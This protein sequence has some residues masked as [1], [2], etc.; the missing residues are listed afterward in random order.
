MPLPIHILTHAVHVVYIC[1][2]KH[3]WKSPPPPPPDTLQRA[4]NIENAPYILSIYILTIQCTQGT[5]LSLYI[6]MEVAHPHLPLRWFSIENWPL[7]GYFNISM[8]TM[9]IY[10]PQH[11]KVS[12][13]YTLFA[14]STCIVH[15]NTVRVDID[16]SV[17]QYGCGPVA[18]GIEVL[19]WI[20]PL[21]KPPI[22]TPGL[23]GCGGWGWGVWGGIVTAWLGY[24]GLNGGGGVGTVD[25]PKFPVSIIDADH[26]FAQ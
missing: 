22:I 13:N 15:R 25:I 16:G 5:F 9:E 6:S 18:V 23:M 20:C 19:V 10:T 4:F 12:N 1:I 3:I 7:G 21:S 11:W 14:L 17:W 26:C 24:V 8:Y 2:Y